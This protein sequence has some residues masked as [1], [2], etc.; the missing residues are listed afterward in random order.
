M[1][2]GEQPH[3]AALAQALQSA[4]TSVALAIPR[5]DGPDVF[6]ALADGCADAV[7]R[8][9]RVDLLVGSADGDPAA[10][11]AVANRIGYGADAR[12]GRALLGTRVTGSG[13]S[14]L[15]W[16]SAPGQLVGVVTDHAWVGETAGKPP[17][18]GRKSPFARIVC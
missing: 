12:R 3:A 8:G 4:R 11:T 9:V 15:L 18:R 5:L 1:L 6:E 16:D 13:A 10:L 17:R 7:T 2:R 14:L